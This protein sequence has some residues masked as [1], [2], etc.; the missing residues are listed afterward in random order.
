MNFDLFVGLTIISIIV[1]GVLFRKPIHDSVIR[2]LAK[3]F[4]DVY[5]AHSAKKHIY[6]RGAYAI[7]K[8]TTKE[9]YEKR[10]AALEAAS[11]RHVGDTE[12]I[13][14]RPVL[15][16][17]GYFQRHFVSA[18]NE[19]SI[20]VFHLSMKQKR[21]E[22]LVHGMSA[23]TAFNTGTIISS[24]ATEKDN[25]Q[26]PSDIPSQ[27]IFN[28]IP[29]ETPVDEFIKKHQHEVD[30][31]LENREGSEINPVN[32]IDGCINLANEK[33]LLIHE[34]TTKSG[35]PIGEQHIR[36]SIDPRFADYVPEIKKEVH[37]QLEE[38]DL[39]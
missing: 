36:Q 2:K 22:D 27:L 10:Q 5:I 24:V 35:D 20:S 3:A 13:S 14:L 16:N 26:L 11:C 39:L 17:G 30:L 21:Q 15:P 31:Y 33:Q 23:S 6:Q 28:A 1:I 12:N 32:D 4:I 25:H 38:R 34:H 8:E 9:F 37:R 7:N 18:D 29:F 19:M